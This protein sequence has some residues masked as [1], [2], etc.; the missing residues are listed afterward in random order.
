MIL[1]GLGHKA[2]HGKNYV[3]DQMILHAAKAHDRIARSYG[4]AN[5]LKA[6]CRIAFGMTTKD[7]PLLQMVGTDLYRRQNPDI[8]VNALMYQLD[9]ERPDIAIIADV[10][11]PNEARAIQTRGGY[12]INISRQT[13][14]GAPWVAGD[15]DPNHPSETALD[16][17]EGWDHYIEAKDGQLGQLTYRAQVALNLILGGKL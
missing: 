5:T 1:I 16:N 11:F 12:L 9:E 15:R 10:R 17:Y 3:A 7:A 8:W 2:R 4:F 6:H 14:D 13:A